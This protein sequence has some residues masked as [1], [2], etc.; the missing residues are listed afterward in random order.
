MTDAGADP[1][2]YTTDW[3]ALREPADAAARS[4]EL[5]EVLRVDLR[6]PD[7]RSPL[8]VHDLGCGSGSMGRWLAPLLPGPQ[9][10]VLHDRDRDLLE[11]AASAPGT[12]PDGAAVTVET[13]RGPLGALTTGD[14]VGSDLV[15]A[16]ALLDV[17]TT[18]ELDRV[19]AAI[20]GAG[21]PALFA[22]TVAGRVALAPPDPA[23]GV[24]VAAFNSHQRRPAGGRRLLG[25][26]AT[27]AAAEAFGRH[28]YV[29]DT[30]PSPWRLGPDRAGLA[31]RWLDGWLGA[32]AE[33]SARAVRADYAG[34]RRADAAAGRLGV[35]VEHTDLLARPPSG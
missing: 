5:V 34:R 24:V 19:V 13:R 1:S 27:Q 16:S 35:V 22:L 12:P 25:P 32:A 33:Q 15:T 9:H 7:R 3:L 18:D 11:A 4:A 31:V 2:T 6:A 21:V 17:L 28:G 14:L 26:T 10:W 23:D 20:A 30:R 8:V 29:V